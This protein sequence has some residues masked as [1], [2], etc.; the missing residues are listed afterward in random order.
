MYL[1]VAGTQFES[2]EPFCLWG[3]VASCLRSRTGCS[4]PRISGPVANPPEPIQ[5]VYTPGFQALSAQMDY[6][7]SAVRSL[8]WSNEWV[9]LRRDH[10]LKADDI[11]R[12]G[13]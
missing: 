12:T 4:S 6:G 2:C 11:I 8:Y 5:A 7:K 10:R 9:R 3:L 13:D 1:C